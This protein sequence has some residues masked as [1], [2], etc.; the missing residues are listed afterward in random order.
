MTP[1][2]LPS[3]TPSVAMP[4]LAAPPTPT[5]SGAMPTHRPASHVVSAGQ[6]AAPMPPASGDSR[7]SGTP[8]GHPRAAGPSAPQRPVGEIPSAA[9]SASK[10][11]SAPTSQ[12][13]S[14]L[15]SSFLAQRNADQRRARAYNLAAAFLGTATRRSETAAAPAPARKVARFITAETA[16]SRLQLADGKLPELHLREGGKAEKKAA[17]AEDKSKTV[18]PLVMFAA[19]SLSVVFSII[20]V[21]VDFNPPNR[22]TVRAQDAAR[23]QIKR[24]Y[25]GDQDLYTNLQTA[26]PLKP[27]QILLREAQQAHTRGDAKTERACYRK[28][29]DMLRAERET[30]ARGVTG[31]RENDKQLEEH[32]STLLND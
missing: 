27:Y 3:M 15:V 4:P 10:P 25:F 26:K 21:M 2:M 32:I 16:E 18:N 24:N 9:P 1:G 30:F 20:L 11:Q 7:W 8:G 6:P 29:L 19:L 17:D 13:A 23:A 22:S 12:S 14:A 28:V 5:G 31:S